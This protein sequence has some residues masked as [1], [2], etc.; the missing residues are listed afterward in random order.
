[1]NYRCPQCIKNV[2]L[3][4]IGNDVVTNTHHLYCCECKRFFDMNRDSKEM[5]EV[6]NNENT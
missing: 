4:H 6:K 3:T 5:K 1:M 2:Y